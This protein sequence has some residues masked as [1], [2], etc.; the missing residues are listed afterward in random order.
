MTDT[1]TFA[2]PLLLK[3]FRARFAEIDRRSS[4]ILA[5]TTRNMDEWDALW[6]EGDKLLNEAY[7]KLPLICFGVADGKCWYTPQRKLGSKYIVL[8]WVW[9]GAD[10]YYLQDG[11]E[12]VMSRETVEKRLR[13]EKLLAELFGSREK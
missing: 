7:R 11:V 8:V 5:A 2:D 3:S 1:I 12:V 4:D 6:A 10:H 13:G 9:G